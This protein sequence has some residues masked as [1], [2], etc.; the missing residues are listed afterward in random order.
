MF[1]FLLSSVASKL[2]DV[3]RRDLCSFLRFLGRLFG[4]GDVSLGEYSTDSA[5]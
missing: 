3:N 2:S 1:P 4:I 5:S